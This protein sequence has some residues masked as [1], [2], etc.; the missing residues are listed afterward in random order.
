[1]IPLTT[2][3][4][5]NQNF[6]KKISIQ[7]TTEMSLKLHFKLYFQ[8]CAQSVDYHN[9]SSGD[10]ICSYYFETE[11]PLI[12]IPPQPVGGCIFHLIVFFFL[13]IGGCSEHVLFESRGVH[14]SPSLK[15]FFNRFIQKVFY[16]Q[17]FDLWYS[18]Q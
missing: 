14:K 2:N 3:R 6:L 5:Y 18:D 13:L 1:M 17:E 9:V 11:R 12:W 16:I 7:T 8:L 4:S 10:N 15:H